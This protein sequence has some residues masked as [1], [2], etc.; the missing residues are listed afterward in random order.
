M[1]A[2]SSGSM[3]DLTLKKLTKLTTLTKVSTFRGSTFC[4]SNYFR[5]QD[6]CARVTG[7]TRE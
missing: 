1:L 2:C 7:E 6:L 5:G 3:L 4:E